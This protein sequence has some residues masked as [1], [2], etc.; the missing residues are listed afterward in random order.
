MTEINPDFIQIGNEINNGFLLPEGSF[1]NLP[2]MKLF[3]KTAIQAVRESNK[4]YNKSAKIILHF[5]G[6][7]NSMSFYSN[8]EDIDY[9]IIGLSY[10]PMWHGKNLDA[11]K[12]NL[13][14]LSTTFKKSTLIVETSYPFTLG[15]NDWTDNVIGL[16][17]QLISDYPAS[18]EGQ[19]NYLAKIKEITRS[20][21]NCLGFC[22]WGGEW[23]SYQGNTATNGSTWENQAFLDFN[24]KALPILENY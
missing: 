11:L 21:P 5:A 22:Y 15:W 17:N 20:V 16:N 9:D 7:E 12:A 1:T 2:T 3:I 23:V 13:T 6:F 14:N 19:S 8:F 18:P 10:Y 24:N 4:A